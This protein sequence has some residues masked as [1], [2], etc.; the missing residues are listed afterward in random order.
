[1]RHL[2]L[3]TQ[4]LLFTAICGVQSCTGN[5]DEI[6]KRKYEV[7]DE[8][9][10]RENYNVGSAM[11]GLQ[12]LVIPT[13]EHLNQFNEILLS[14]AFGGY[15]ESI[16]AFQEKFSTYNPT[17]DWL[18][19]SFIDVIPETY[20]FYR[21]LFALT[22]NEVA[23]ALGKIMR[24]AIMHRTTDI[25]GPIPYSQV[26]EDKK[27]SLKVAYDSQRDVYVQ[28]FKE[29]DE[30]LKV[31]NDNIGLSAESFRKFDDVYYGEVSKWIKYT[32]SLKLRMAMRLSYVE[33]ALAQRMAE[34]AVTAGVI[35]V[36][37]DNAMLHVED[38]RIAMIY[39][40]W[41]DHRIGADLFC[42]MNGYKDP[43][44]EKMFTEIAEGGF[45]GLRIGV[46]PYMPKDK[47]KAWYSN[48]IISNT[49]PILWMNAAEVAFLRAEGALRGWNMGNSAKEWYN[50]GIA[51]SFEERGAVGVSEYALDDRN[52]PSSHQDPN[53]GLDYSGSNGCYT[54]VKWD[55]TDNA[56]EVNF[57][58]IMIQ[59]W[60]AIFPLAT[61]AWSEYRRTGYPKLLPAFDN[62]SGGRLGKIDKDKRARRLPYPAAEYKE[63]AQNVAAAVGLLGGSDDANT[64]VWWDVADKSLR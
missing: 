39:N 40:D 42:Y 8:E 43:R 21:S 2:N 55:D 62:L 53:S 1:M 45:R 63:N 46:K 12:G 61:E 26:M 54:T 22:D 58:R 37:A 14:G 11:K 49:D 30:A 5:F 7:T 38:N 48:P 60:I 47:M 19:N 23:Q 59:K 35:V 20:P 3:I 44:R 9:L 27:E 6:N 25:Y 15:V 24:V 17:E 18:E 36:N 51:L 52:I 29:L 64:R 13:E 56:K 28:M 16:T 50:K 34:E 57:E 32:N 10:A 41:N 33:P 4:I 31:L